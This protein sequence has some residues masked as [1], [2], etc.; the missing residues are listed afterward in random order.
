MAGPG[1]AQDAPSPSA[2]AAAAQE[3]TPA[4][5]A[6]ETSALKSGRFARL[7][8]RGA[9]LIDG[10]G[11]PPRGPVDIV[12]EKDRIVKVVA[13]GAAGLD[14][15]PE[16]RPPLNGGREIDAAGKFV[17]PGF[18]NLHGHIHTSD[19]GQ[20]VPK[21][22][23]YK[24]WLAHGI[25]T[26]R[27][28]GNGEGAAWTAAEAAKSARG[29]IDAPR[30]Y[31]YPFF[32]ANPPVDVDTPEAARERIRQLKAE[33]AFGVKFFGAP[34]EILFA[35]FDEAKAQGLKTTMHHA[36]IDVARADVLDTSAAGLGSMEHWYGLPEA[37]F[38]DETVQDY[39]LDYN[40]QN[41]QDRFEH[42][43]RLWAQ[44]AEPGSAQW[45][46]VRR[47]LIDRDFA[48]IPT[49]TIYA[50]SR[51]WMRARRAE[52]HDTYT[53]PSLWAFFAPDR[54]A[55]GS[56]WF[57]W[58]TEQEV[59]WRENY[60]RWMAFVN[61]YKN[62]GGLVG[63][64]ED[65]G[66]IYSTYGFGYIGE[67]ELLREAGFHPLEV[68][69]S[70]TLNGARILGVDDIGSI[71]PG[72]KADLIVVDENPLANLKVLYATGHVKLDDNNKPARVGGV[73]TIVK[74]GFVYD[75]EAL[76]EEIRAMV[77]AE[78]SKAGVAPGPM[79]IVGFD[80]PRADATD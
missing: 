3:A 51:D 49:I 56:Y 59:A 76:R 42:A 23:V 58:G 32:R 14:I 12:I 11:A 4:P 37:L 1:A 28:V 22:Y 27:E 45:N 33:G 64:G 34:P 17:L 20:G 62:N 75:G 77:A 43:G 63:A 40:Y 67:L 66:Y 48:L 36:Q 9:T 46:R 69:M 30:I 18:V 54:D 78:K 6:G 44:A 57:D 65:A 2:S 60:R 16:S 79:P 15:D 24:L 55:H 47:T 26:V 71:Q 8:V 38:D 50:A 25:T 61:D 72:K 7:I 13:V 29:E 73:G 80:W 53:M 19:T 31:P 74:D 35:A 41:E 52:W 21:E 39:P 5:T 70:A 10:A 68:I